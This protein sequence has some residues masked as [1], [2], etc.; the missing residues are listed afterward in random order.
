[1]N[2]YGHVRLDARR[3]LQFCAFAN[4]DFLDEFDR[5]IGFARQTF[6]L[7]I[8]IG[9]TIDRL[10]T[11]STFHDPILPRS[12]SR[13]S[14]AYRT[15]HFGA[16]VGQSAMHPSRSVISLDLESF[17]SGDPGFAFY[18]FNGWMI[19]RAAKVAKAVQTHHAMASCGSHVP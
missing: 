2:Q 17:N 19:P 10:I 11:R 16:E 3:S 5:H 18:Y 12:L 7:R 8:R 4:I 13:G 14:S 6:Y 1:M 15:C 9:G